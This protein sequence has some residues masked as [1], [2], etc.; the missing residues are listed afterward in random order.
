MEITYI[1]FNKD[2]YVN[3][4]ELFY[5]LKDLYLNPEYNNMQYLKLANLIEDKFPWKEIRLTITEEK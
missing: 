2:L 4:R 3:W 5:V 1:K